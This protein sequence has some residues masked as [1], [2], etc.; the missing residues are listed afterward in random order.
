MKKIL[1]NKDQFVGRKMNEIITLDDYWQGYKLYM[2]D[3]AVLIEKYSTCDGYSAMTEREILKGAINVSVKNDYID[4]RSDYG[5]EHRPIWNIISAEIKIT[6]FGE[7]LIKYGI[8]T[9]QELKVFGNEEFVRKTEEYK[10]YRQ[11]DIDK[12]IAILAKYGINVALK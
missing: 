1:T 9:E 7:D 4:F 3:D 8:V 6:P 2:F 10:S 12:C 11:Q 5:S